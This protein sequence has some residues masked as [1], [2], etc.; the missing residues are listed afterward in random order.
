M[1]QEREL[2]RKEMGELE[3]TLTSPVCICLKSG[4]SKNLP[5]GPQGTCSLT[6]ETIKLTVNSW[7]SFSA[8][9]NAGGPTACQRY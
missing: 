8:K 5:R 7:R 4:M 9:M 3:Y 1:G 2:G 6:A